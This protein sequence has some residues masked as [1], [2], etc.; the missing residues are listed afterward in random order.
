MRLWFRFSQRDAIALPSH[1]TN[2]A[3]SRTAEARHIDNRFHRRADWL[4]LR[5]VDEGNVC[6]HFRPQI[7]VR[8]RDLHLHLH[9]RL[10]TIRFRRN[11]IDHALVLAIGIGVR[12]DD[13]LLLRPELCEIVLTDIEFHLQIV[14]IRQRYDVAFGAALADEAGSD[15]LAL[16]DCA[17]E[18]SPVTG[19]WMT[20]LVS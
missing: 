16:L 1:I 6:I 18:N 2:T 3:L 4:L 13:A 12:G 5:I 8:I 9:R 15:K 10:L 7:V 20:V 19:A 11:L 14:E 17:L